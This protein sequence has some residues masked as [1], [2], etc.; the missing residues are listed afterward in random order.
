MDGSESAALIAH[1]PA[2]DLQ[3]LESDPAHLN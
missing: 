2:I 3:H 1:K